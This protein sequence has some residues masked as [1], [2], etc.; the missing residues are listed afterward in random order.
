MLR[1]MNHRVKN[2]SAIIT[3]MVKLSAR[4]ATSIKQLTDDICE[5]VYALGRSHSL[6]VG[7]AN[8][9]TPL[10]TLL[11]VAIDPVVNGQQVDME[12]LDVALPCRL[13]T[14]CAMILHE[15][16]TNS[17]KYGAFGSPAG[18]LLVEWSLANGCLHIDWNE[19]GFALPSATPE[20]AGLRHTDDHGER[21]SDER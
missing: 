14:P 2:L 10:R 12:G 3:A 11:E 15:W 6:T 17:C 7:D 9:V 5:R 21:A 16:V 1:E 19:R 18:R 13:V 20:K 8:G 4:D